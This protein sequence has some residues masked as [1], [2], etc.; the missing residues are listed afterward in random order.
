[1]NSIRVYLYTSTLWQ[2]ADSPQSPL[3][4]SCYTLCLCPR[5]PLPFPLLP[6]PSTLHY[7]LHPFCTPC[8]YTQSPTG[9]SALFRML[10]MPLLQMPRK[11]RYLRTAVKSKKRGLSPVASFLCLKTRTVG[12]VILRTGSLRPA[13]LPVPITSGTSSIDGFEKCS[14][15]VSNACCASLLHSHIALT[16]LSF[17]NGHVI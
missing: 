14:F 8:S 16:C 3:P 9:P 12:L 7:S 5:P 10:A 6:Y 13:N 11:C 17:S 1:M 15:N 4:I 2:S